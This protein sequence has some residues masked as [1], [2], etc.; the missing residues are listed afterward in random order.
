MQPSGGGPYHPHGAVF[1]LDA[2]TIANK[3][4]GAANIWSTHGQHGQHGQNGPRPC[5]TR[6]QPPT[7]RTRPCTMR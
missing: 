1:K 7:P 4:W 6:A 5:I 2:Y 3:R